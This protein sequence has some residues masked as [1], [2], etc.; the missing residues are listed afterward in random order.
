MNMEKI[1]MHKALLQK[2]LTFE[3]ITALQIAYND[4]S[5]DDIKK[6]YNGAEL[7]ANKLYNDYS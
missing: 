3:E 5:K 7:D 6:I 4:Y 2:A 1:Y